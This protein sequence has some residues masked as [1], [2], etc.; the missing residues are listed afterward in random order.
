MKGQV[1]LS[2]VHNRIAPGKILEKKI[3]SRH[4]LEIKQK[5][6]KNIFFFPL[7]EKSKQENLRMAIC[8][9]L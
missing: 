8:Y 1:I 7:V 2:I 5:H 4:W 9:L 6:L 3:S